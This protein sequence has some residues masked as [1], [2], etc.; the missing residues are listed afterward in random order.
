MTIKYSFIFFAAS[1]C[2][3]LCSNVAITQPLPGVLQKNNV[4]IMNLGPNVNSSGN[5]YAPML[6]TDGKNLYFTKDGFSGF[7]KK[8][9]FWVRV[10][11]AMG[12]RICHSTL[13]ADGSFSPT[14]DADSTFNNMIYD[15]GC[16]SIS[17]DNQTTY[18]IG[19]DRP[20]GMGN[21]D[22]YVADLIGTELQNVR[23]L[24]PTLTRN[25]GNHSHPFPQMVGHYFLQVT[26]QAV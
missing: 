22:I 26:A 7:I 2:I 19:C 14:I 25:I 18:F 21:C 6:T 11:D 8:N 5:E 3:M 20:D 1:F 23:N 10:K 12:H 13:N 9:G 15:Q 4:S 17:P 16:S 24:G